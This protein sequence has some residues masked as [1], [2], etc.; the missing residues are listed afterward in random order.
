VKDDVHAGDTV[1][2]SFEYEAYFEPTP[3]NAVEGVG[4]DHL[5]LLKLRPASAGYLESWPQYRNVVVA[6]PR[7]VQAKVFRLVSEWKNGIKSRLSPD[8]ED[9]DA[10][11]FLAN[12]IEIRAGFNAHGDL[13]SHL[14]VVWPYEFWDDLN[15]ERLQLSET[16][17]RLIR[18]FAADM[19]TRGV[20]VFVAPPPAPRE[21]YD[22]NRPFIDSLSLRLLELSESG[23][24]LLLGSPGSFVWPKSYFFDNINHLSGEGRALRTTKMLEHL[25]SSL[26]R[27]E[28][29]VSE[30]S[31]GADRGR[32][33]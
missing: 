9:E 16:L 2:L 17:L 31:C 1:V 33:C 15:L 21:W 5:V 23:S 24:L 4:S 8:Q 28:H 26:H 3:Y 19:H 25:R 27:Q 7:V 20:T 30:S 22:A 18:G 32:T 12:R 29:A 13:V 10:D 6:V 11:T 14:G